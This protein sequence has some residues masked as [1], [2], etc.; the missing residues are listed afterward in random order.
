MSAIDQ[1][2]PDMPENDDL[3]DSSII[4]NSDSFVS[5]ESHPAI[6]GA[7]DESVIFDFKSKGLLFSTSNRKV[8]THVF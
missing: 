7:S 8:C 3:D 6:D 2:I 1:I 5:V 4:D